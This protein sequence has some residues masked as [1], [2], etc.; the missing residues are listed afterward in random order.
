MSPDEWLRKLETN[1]DDDLDTTPK[2]SGSTRRRQKKG[3]FL[4]P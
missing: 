2:R 1:A 4:F 3:D